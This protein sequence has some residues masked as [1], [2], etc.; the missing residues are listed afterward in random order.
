MSAAPAAA[1]RAA[2]VYNPVKVASAD[3]LR[4]AVTLISDE[5][6]WLPPLVFETTIED[7]GQHAA[8]RALAE[9]VSAV[10]VAGGDGTV[11]AVAEVMRGTGVRLAVVPSGTGNLLA[12]NLR[13]PLADPEE[14]VRAAIDGDVVAT[15]IGVARLR[16]LTGEVEEHAFVVMAG[17]GLDAA[18]IANTN[19]RLKRQVGW[20]AYVDGAARSLPGAEPFR[21]VYQLD[22]GRLHAAKVQSV[23]FA[24]CG[25]LPAG[26]ELIPEASVFDGVL[27]IALI[28]PSGV[29]GW[30]GVFRK[31]WWDNSVLRRSRLGRRVVERRRDSSV[32]F[33]RGIEMET[34]PVSIQPVELDG[35]EFGQA[36]RLH[37]RIEKGALL[38]AVPHGHPTARL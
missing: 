19:A 37:C 30:L 15:D 27:D 14:M 22:G 38:M 32:R 18:M 1:P 11:R 24:N 16:R 6:G 34:A 5:C 26:I 17:I 35:D 10:L 31:V 9:G 4:S 12:R 29:F 3:A 36:T 33:L 28:Q 8:K 23:L 20:V 21:V 25:A 13:L 7:P 2:L